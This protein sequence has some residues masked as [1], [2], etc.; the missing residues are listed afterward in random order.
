VSRTKDGPNEETSKNDT[1]T[2]H[3]RLEEDQAKTSGARV[4]TVA[5]HKL[6]L[7]ASAVSADPVDPPFATL[8]TLTNKQLSVPA[9]V[10]ESRDAEIMAQEHVTISHPDIPHSQYI[11][12]FPRVPSAPISHVHPLPASPRRP[13]HLVTARTIGVAYVFMF[14]RRRYKVACAYLFMFSRRRYAV[15]CACLFLFSRRM[16]APYPSKIAFLCISSFLETDACT[17]CVRSLQRICIVLS[18]MGCL[19]KH[20]NVMST[21]TLFATRVP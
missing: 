1:R 20:A 9:N 21:S 17:P 13:V 2:S 7:V 15:A 8:P 3:E 18:F 19:C 14:S 4:S 11:Q 5:F 12:P 6:V 16:Y 10:F